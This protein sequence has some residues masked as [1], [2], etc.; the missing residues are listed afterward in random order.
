MSFVRCWTRALKLFVT[1]VS[2]MCQVQMSM[3]DHGRLDQ[4]GTWRRELETSKSSYG[5]AQEDRDRC[6][7]EG[8]KDKTEVF[9]NNN[10]MA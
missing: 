5:E 6:Q 8:R 2:R 4:T 9:L 1:G 7:C 3:D 10:R